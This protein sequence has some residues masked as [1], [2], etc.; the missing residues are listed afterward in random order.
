M[1]GSDNE[2]PASNSASA[3]TLPIPAAISPCKIDTSVNVAKYIKAPTIDTKKLENT[4]LPPTRFAIHSF[5][6]TPAIAV[7]S[8]VEP[9]RK[10]AT[11]TPMASMGIICLGY[12]HEAMVGLRPAPLL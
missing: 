2:G 8:W 9:S 10:P 5:G 6:I 7:S 11:Q 12:F 4:E 1:F 3:G